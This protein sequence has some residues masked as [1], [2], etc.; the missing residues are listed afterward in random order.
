MFVRG[1]SSTSLTNA[2]RSIQENDIHKQAIT[3]EIKIEVVKIYETEVYEI[4][5]LDPSNDGC[6]TVKVLSA[7]F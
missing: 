5:S 3:K 7:A 1:I 6:Y 4:F 2:I